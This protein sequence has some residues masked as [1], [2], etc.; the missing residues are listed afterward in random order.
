MTDWNN[1][2]KILCIRPDNMGDLLMSGPAIRALKSS[3]NAQITIL[4]SSMAAGIAAF[5]PEI[6]EVIIFDMPWVKTADR[7]NSDSLAELIS[8]LRSKQFDAAVVFTVFSQNPLPSA[9]LAYQAGIPKTLAYCRENPYGLVTN[10]IPDEEP[11]TF[12]RHQVERDI[13][14][15]ESIGISVVNKQMQINTPLNAWQQAKAKCEVTGWK[16]NQPWLVLHPGVSELKRQYPTEHWIAAG[17]LLTQKGYQLV[18]TGIAQENALITEICAGIGAQCFNCAGLLRLDELVCLIQHSPLL[19]GVNTGPIHI[20]AAVGTPVV[21]LYAQTNPQ[22]IPWQVPN[23]VLQF[24][25]PDGLQSRNQVIRFLQ[26]TIYN[27]QAI[28]P[29]HNAVVN[30]VE[31][32]LTQSA[33]SNQ[34]SH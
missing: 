29:G 20:A 19:L 31:D 2:S 10:W 24:P 22:H 9:M 34:P 25:V 5:M 23:K 28:T 4:T 17:K 11:Y 14:L 21:V 18:V 12:I 16:S 32:L 26:Q 1:C 33:A 27:D 13:Y 30:A 8:T 6:D 7:E 3:F 15:V